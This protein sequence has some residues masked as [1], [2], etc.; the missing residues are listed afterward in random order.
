MRV[1]QHPSYT[2][3][4]ATIISCFLFF[5]KGN[6]VV[7]AS[8]FLN[9][10]AS[11]TSVAVFGSGGFGFGSTTKK[12]TVKN[13]KKLKKKKKGRLSSDTTF[14]ISPKKD[15]DAEEEKLDRFGLPIRTAENFFPPLPADT[16]L[17]GLANDEETK[18][19]EVQ[20][21]MKKHIPL[22]WDVFNENGVEKEE[23]CNGRK[24]WKVKLLHKSPPV[25][26]VEDFF[27][28]EEC[29]EY[30]NISNPPSNDQSVS[31]L[32]VSSATFSA[33]AQSKRT[34][35][36]WFCYYS[37]VPTLL[38]KAKRLLN[39][40]PIEQMEESQIVR[41][42]TGEEFSWH[43]DE[44]PGSELHN[45][46]QRVGTLLVY[47][48]TIPKD[49][50]GGTVFRDL[51]DAVTGKELTMR[52]KLGSAL[53]FF[54]AFADGTP[55]DRTLHKGEVAIDEK[56]IAQMWLHENKYKPQIP[57]GNSYDGVKELIEAKETLLGFV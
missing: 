15:V 51:K 53:L 52:P 9:T 35:T 33:L 49:K 20:Q 5:L 24:P 30:I 2:K 14:D 11:S 42:R 46:G 28:P 47:L 19:S 40:L 32:E 8:A 1:L 41:Y 39:N 26:S 12:S 7:S 43:Y 34:S 3:S 31:P 44:V 17:V 13:K 23:L 6:Q 18:M 29:Q 57:N 56:M 36:T 16:E 10:K 22:N 27:S 21:F 45:G 48:N 38:A 50:G 4:L 37:Q 55:D 54:P 25:V